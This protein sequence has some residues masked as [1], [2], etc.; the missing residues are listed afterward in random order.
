MDANI[1]KFDEF[2]YVCVNTTDQDQ[3]EV[4]FNYTTT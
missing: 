2:V 4:F 1:A 3:S